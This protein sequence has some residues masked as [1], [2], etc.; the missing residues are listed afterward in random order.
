MST[1]TVCML[2]CK[3]DLYD[4]RIYW[5]EC[6]SLEKKGFNVIHIGI[7]DKNST[8]VSENKITLI[9]VCT[10]INKYNKL[11]RMLYAFLF[12]KIKFRNLLNQALEVKADYY[13]IHDLELNCLTKS[14]RAKLPNSKIIYSIHEDY[15]DMIRDYQNTNGVFTLLKNIYA[16]YIEKWEIGKCKLADHLVAFDDATYN[17]FAGIRGKKN[18][19]LIYNFSN[20]NISNDKPGSKKYDLIY[21]GGMT[22]PRGILEII[23]AISLIKKEIPTIKLLLLGTIHDPNFRLEII[24]EIKEKRLSEN[25]DLVSSIPHHEVPD[26]LQVSKVGL[27][28]LL[29]IP[30]YH[31]NIPIKQFEYM[32][33]GLPVIGSNLPPIQKF[34]DEADAGIIVNPKKPKEIAEAAITLLTN[35]DLYRNY[36]INGKEAAANKYTWKNEE[37]KVFKIYQPI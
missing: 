34:I 22:K 33:A 26:F 23:E 10:G 16:K 35:T 18:T 37:E 15:P 30:K 32:A 28:V 12:P 27:V 5:K 17:K 29:P 9:S 20:F 7:G 1:K 2:S 4:D 19:S 36:S 6:L 21:L 11:L 8:Q 13:N 25:I 24:N 14:I 3:H 31:K